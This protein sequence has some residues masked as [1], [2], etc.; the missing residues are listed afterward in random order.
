MQKIKFFFQTF[1]INYLFIIA[2]IC[3]LN[4]FIFSNSAFSVDYVFF[5]LDKSDSMWAQEPETGI[6]V[7]QLAKKKIYSIIKTLPAKSG[8]RK[9]KLILFDSKLR[10]TFEFNINDIND[11]RKK[12]DPIKPSGRTMIGERLE[13]VRKEIINTGVHDVEVHLFSDLK[14][15][16]IGKISIDDAIEKLNKSL[17]KGKLKNIDWTLCA[18]TWKNVASDYLKEKLPPGTITRPIIQ[19][20]P[21]I[22]FDKPDHF[23]MDIVENNDKIIIKGGETKIF[24]VIDPAITEKKIE[25]VI[26]ADCPDIPSKILLNDKE[27][28]TIDRKSLS[29]NGKFD[30]D[31]KVQFKNIDSWP[32]QKN[33]S[34]WKNEHKM[35]FTP[36]VFPVS[37]QSEKVVEQPKKRS[38][39]FKFISEPKFQISNYPPGKKMFF[40]DIL[41]GANLKESIEIKWNRGAIGKKLTWQLPHKT[42]LISENGTKIN[43]LLLDSLLKK[44]V[45]IIIN[46]VQTIK[47]EAVI[48]KLNSSSQKINIPF[49]LIA[50]KPIIDFFINKAKIIIPPSVNENIINNFIQLEPNSRNIKSSINLKLFGCEGAGCDNLYFSIYDP[51][52][53]ELKSILNGPTTTFPIQKYKTMTISIQS[54]QIGKRSL[55]LRITSDKSDIIINNNRS[56]LFNLNYDILVT[57]PDVTWKMIK[58]KKSCGTKENPIYFK[59][60]GEPY[61]TR[62]STSSV[63]AMINTESD[64]ILNLKIKIQL[65]SV[66]HIIKKVLFDNTQTDSCLINQFL[67]NPNIIFEIDSSKKGFIWA[68]NGNGVIRFTIESENKKITATFPEIYYKV[69]LMP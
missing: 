64:M 60:R 56:N 8:R 66:N 54:E 69:K 43:S 41:E 23:F 9:V 25:L 36:T 20:I 46:N 47:N 37:F 34:F 5:L 55:K 13:E 14:E 65:S 51:E 57:P 67:V 17:R 16:E 32:L 24:G 19:N 22:I 18:Y 7:F 10:K 44:T 40:D 59:T 1:K 58:G 63:K 48:F 42:Y 31:I 50:Q 33:I 21:R 4:I 62:S 6:S 49:N 11:A 12:L 68:K 53:P 26:Q 52:E 35:F 45:F 29:N 2:F 28:L 39:I 3:F 38:T 30:F 27:S 61:S 15:N